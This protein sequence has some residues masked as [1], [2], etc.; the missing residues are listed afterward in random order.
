MTDTTRSS[1]ESRLISTMTYSPGKK[2]VV[3]VAE[4]QLMSFLSDFRLTIHTQQGRYADCSVLNATISSSDG[5]K[6]QVF[7]NAPQ[8]ISR[9]ERASMSLRSS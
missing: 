6:T 5:M 4:D 9:A 1:S 2:I 7:F 3:D 8:I